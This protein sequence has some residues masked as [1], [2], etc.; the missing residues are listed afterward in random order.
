MNASRVKIVK[1]D[2]NKYL[3]I[4]INMQ[5]DFMGRDD[6]ISEYE[7][8]AI[9]EVTG[10][11]ADFE[12]ARFSHNT[13]PNLDMAINYEF[14]FYDDSQPITANTVGNWSSSYLNEGFSTQ[15]VYYYS[16]PF[17]R[18]FFKLDLYDTQDE[19]TQQIYLSII[20]PIQQ[21]LTQTVVLNN[22]LP[23]VEIKKP[24]MVLDSIG[25]D[26]EG[27][28]IYWLRSRNFID[29]SEFYMTAK[30]FNARLGV[31]KQMTNTKQDLITPNK[32]QFNNADYFYY[33][34]NLNYSDKTYEVFST[35]TQL[36]VG[37]T[38]SPIIWYEYVNP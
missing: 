19:R 26:K 29:I 33:K 32:F 17:T 18:S 13:F 16:K 6:S 7:A 36:R 27:F 38:T 3:N 12:V 24:T 4:P 1:D 23:P 9:K 37:D 2:T 11:A 31:F 10:I 22:L 14:N 34:V 20:L 5:W 25:A 30:F 28:Y 8:K 35:S 21:G 15:E